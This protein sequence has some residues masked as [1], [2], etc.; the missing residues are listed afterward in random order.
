MSARKE[1]QAAITTVPTSIALKTGIIAPVI[2]AIS[3]AWT[4]TPASV[5]LTAPGSRIFIALVVDI[6]ECDTGSHN[7]DHSCVN[8]PGTYYC[9][10]DAGCLLDSNGYS[11]YGKESLYS[12]SPGNYMVNS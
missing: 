12:H 1:R 6:N 8:L 3:L 4:I 11:C 10:C 7:C 5:S 9:Q 2:L